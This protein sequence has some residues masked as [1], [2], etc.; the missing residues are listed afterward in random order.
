M[1]VIAETKLYEKHSGRVRRF[2]IAVYAP[3]RDPLPNGDFRCRLFVTGRRPRYAF[4]IDTFQALNL[5]FASLRIEARDM[6]ARKQ[7]LYFD[8]KLEHPFDVRLH[9]L[10]DHSVYLKYRANKSLTGST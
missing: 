1:H 8:H 10:G 5:A 2:R 3:E 6:L 9:L 7:R 4:G